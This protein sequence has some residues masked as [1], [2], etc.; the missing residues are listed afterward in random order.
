MLLNSANVFISK[1]LNHTL[2]RFVHNTDSLKKKNKK[3]SLGVTHWF[4]QMNWKLWFIQE[5]NKLLS[6]WVSNWIIDSNSLSTTLTDSKTKQAT[7]FIS[8]SI[9]HLLEWFMHNIDS[10]KKQLFLWVTWK[11]QSNDLVQMA[12]SFKNETT[13]C[14][15]VET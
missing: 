2:K 10:F 8:E 4:I 1:S 5:Q 15:S 13:V 9:K 7:V 14:C 3:L 12:Y 6:V 11:I